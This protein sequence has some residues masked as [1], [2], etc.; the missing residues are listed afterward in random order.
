[1][2]TFVDTARRESALR[3]GFVTRITAF[4]QLPDEI[5][6]WM[7]DECT[8]WNITT[9]AA[10][11]TS[12]LVCLESRSDIAFGY[13]QAI[14]VGN[15]TG[16]QQHCL[17]KQSCTISARQ[18]ITPDVLNRVFTHMGAKKTALDPRQG[19]E[20]EKR[21]TKSQ[22]PSIPTDYSTCSQAIQGKQDRCQQTSSGF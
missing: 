3:A 1:M 12:V 18:I 4:K 20:G 9:C 22:N 11:L 14:E 15:F 7:L 2:L 17:T 13:L 16:L 6:L 8:N 21:R 5:L 10:K 19:I